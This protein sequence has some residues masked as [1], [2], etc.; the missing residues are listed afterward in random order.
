MPVLSSQGSQ[1]LL[2]HGVALIYNGAQE[3]CVTSRKLSSAIKVQFDVFLAHPQYT[4]I[5]VAA[6]F[7]SIKWFANKL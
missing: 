4:L 2:T 1:A 5:Q 6:C 7:S 3:I